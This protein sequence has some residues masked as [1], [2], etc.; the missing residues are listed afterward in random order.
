MSRTLL[1]TGASGG[2]GGH[3]ARLALQAGWRVAGTFLAHPI[4][5][6]DV[7]AH[8][9]DIRDR[10]AVIELLHTLQPD[11]V[12]HTAY[13][14]SCPDFWAIN[15]DG[16]AHVAAAARDCGARLVHISS[17]AIFDGRNAPYDESAQPAPIT[18]YGASKA[19]AE[20]AVHAPGS[21]ARTAVSAAALDAPYGVMG[22]GWADSS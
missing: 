12:V 2:L 15:A 6:Q 20:T 22:A 19:A 13:R 11:A 7:E 9:L 8:A 14:L 1:I 4:E 21:S 5:Q 3:L 10:R 17:D 18:P 16:T